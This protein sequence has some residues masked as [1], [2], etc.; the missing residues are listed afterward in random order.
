MMLLRDLTGEQA[1]STTSALVSSIGIPGMG[2]T[3]RLLRMAC[4]ISLIAGKSILAAR[5]QSGAA[6]TFQRGQSAE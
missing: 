3:H 4:A 6:V 1:D 5:S 2:V